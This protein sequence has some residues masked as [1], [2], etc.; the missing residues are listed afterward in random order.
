MPGEKGYWIYLLLN[1]MDLKKD[2]TGTDCKSA[3]AGGEI[4]LTWRMMKKLSFTFNYEGT[5]EKD[6]HFDRIYINLTQ[7]F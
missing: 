6:R 1:K 7:R 3:P 5:F 2:S 4:N